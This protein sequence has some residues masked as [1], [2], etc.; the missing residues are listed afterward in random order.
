[1]FFKVN[2]II[3]EWQWGARLPNSNQDTIELQT[4]CV[5]MHNSDLEFIPNVKCYWSHY[6]LED[7]A[8]PTY[9]FLN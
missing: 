4:G 5:D 6:K 3:K 9:I 8:I 2:L 7:V 1:M